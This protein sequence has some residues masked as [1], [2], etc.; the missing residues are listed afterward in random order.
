MLSAVFDHT[1]DTLALAKEW[2]TV[3][4]AEV[5]LNQRTRWVSLGDFKAEVPRHPPVAVAEPGP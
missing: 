1:G 3:A 2:G 5:D 4:V